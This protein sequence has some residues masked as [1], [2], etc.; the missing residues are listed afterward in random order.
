MPAFSILETMDSKP[1]K[2]IPTPV[3]GEKG[4]KI[5]KITMLQQGSG[6]LNFQ[7]WL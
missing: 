4:L 1:D 2:I 3:L 5:D 6:L 7:T